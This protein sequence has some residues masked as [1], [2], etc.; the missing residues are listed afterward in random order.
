MYRIPVHGER[1][2]LEQDFKNTL[3]LH[4]QRKGAEIWQDIVDLV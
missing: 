1:V 2:F 4:E 3:F